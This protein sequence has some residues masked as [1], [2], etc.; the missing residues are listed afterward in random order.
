MR[1]L[2]QCLSRP[3][4]PVP[5]AT[6]VGSDYH[7]AATMTSGDSGSDG[8]EEE[9]RQQTDEQTSQRRAEVEVEAVS[10]RQRREATGSPPWATEEDIRGAEEAQLAETA[11]GTPDVSPP[12]A[13][14]AALTEKERRRQAALIC[15][16]QYMH[17]IQYM[18]TT[19]AV[20]QLWA[21]RFGDDFA[22]QAR[23]QGYSESL[24]KV[25][26]FVLS[27]LSGTLSDSCGRR[28][29]LRIPELAD[30][31]QRLLLLP[32]MSVPAALAAHAIGGGI[33]GSSMSGWNAALGDLYAHDPEA[34][35]GWQSRLAVGSTFASVFMPLIGSYLAQRSLRL[36]LFISL[37]LCLINL[38]IVQFGVKDTLPKSRRKPFAWRA[39]NPLAFVTLFRRGAKLRRLCLFSVL[40]S[41]ER[42]NRSLQAIYREC[43]NGRLGCV[44]VDAASSDGRPSLRQRC[45][46]W[47]GASSS[48]AASRA[49]RRCSRCRASPP[50][51][52]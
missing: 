42:N 2:N 19:P 49:P 46:S 28:A 20:T 14:T 7:A 23:V 11:R 8:S 21:D 25:S 36:P 13:F 4:T 40:S 22:A 31:F 15:A 32:F 10:R 47:A 39:A 37:V 16:T 26:S 44:T 51:R 1:C 18:L 43:S 35:G 34:N 12:A 29:V 9:G 30:T 41:L 52:H 5:I 45:R 17:F 24:Q 27:P 6:P 48:G 38:G 33:A 3:P 50:R